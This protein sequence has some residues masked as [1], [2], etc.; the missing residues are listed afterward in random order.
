MNKA[1]FETYSRQIAQK[2]NFEIDEIIYAGTFYT[3]EHI[4]NMIFTGVY[5]N[6]RAILKVY[7]DPRLSDEPVAHEAY[8]KNNTNSQLV[9]PELYAYEV[10]GPKEGWLI[11]E[12]LPEGGEFFKSPLGENK[13]EF[14]ELFLRYRQTFP[15]TPT[16]D[17]TLREYLPA[18]KFHLMR[19]NLWFHL[20]ME[21]EESE[22]AD[23]KEPVLDPKEFMPR[24]LKSLEL[25]R[26]VFPKVK[27][28]WV[29]GHFKPQELYKTKNSDKYYLTDFAHSRMLPQGYEMAFIIWAD[30]FMRADW[31]MSYDE[32]REEVFEWIEKFRPV[33][34]ELGIDDYDVL[35]RASIVERCLG[36]ILADIA[37]S[38]KPRVEKLAR[39][40][41]L[42]KL[43]DEFVS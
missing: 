41:L 6:K 20:A 36:T 37:A 13:D 16:R 33:A 42:Y 12:E 30:H 4:R 28:Q 9:A 8:N 7:N 35:I 19:I 18:D 11:M 26:A 1:E 31:Q 17:L 21:R 27:M 29:H 10:I 43:I 22:K 14:V 15:K 24:Y 38:D 25:I 2:A 3:Q 32:W 5:Q 39:L 40:A 23:G 34:A